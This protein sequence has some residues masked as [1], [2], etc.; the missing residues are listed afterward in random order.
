MLRIAGDRGIMGNYANG[1]VF[2]FF[3]WTGAVLVALASL[4]MVVLTFVSG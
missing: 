4:T 2:N 3:A 1:R